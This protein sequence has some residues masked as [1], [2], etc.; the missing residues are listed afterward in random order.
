MFAAVSAAQQIVL[1]PF[2]ILYIARNRV[3]RDSGAVVSVGVGRRTFFIAY[4][5]Y[6][7]NIIYLYR[8]VYVAVL[9]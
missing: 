2:I 5:Q 4:T 1:G 6:Y 9:L 7:N 8:C 3:C